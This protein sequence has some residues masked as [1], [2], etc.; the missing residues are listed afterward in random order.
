MNNFWIVIMEGI[1]LA[2]ITWLMILYTLILVF[3]IVQHSP[4]FFFTQTI[5]LVFYFSSTLVNFFLKK[6]DEGK[7]L[8]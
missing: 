4:L 7:H 5:A 8:H 1:S 6:Y 2:I 3:P